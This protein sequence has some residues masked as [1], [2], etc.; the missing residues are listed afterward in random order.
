MV[1]IRAGGD[2]GLVRVESQLH[3]R[4]GGLRGVDD[5]SDHQGTLLS[6]KWTWR[7]GFQNKWRVKET[8]SAMRR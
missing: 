3:C 6:R 5:E 8:D 4:I 7:G 1:R 2:D